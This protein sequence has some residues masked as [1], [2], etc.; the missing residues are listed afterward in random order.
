MTEWIG[1]D[2]GPPPVYS[3]RLFY[4]G[5]TRTK[6]MRFGVQFT[7]VAPPPGVKHSC[8]CDHGVTNEKKNEL[9]P[10]LLPAIQAASA[11]C[12]ADRRVP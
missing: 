11:G 10:P 12:A 3:F 7:G 1:G 4:L 9:P 2:R 5:E 6:T 8:L